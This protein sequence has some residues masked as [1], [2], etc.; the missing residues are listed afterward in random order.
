MMGRDRRGGRKKLKHKTVRHAG[1]CLFKQNPSRFPPR[2]FPFFLLAVFFWL[3]GTMIRGQDAEYRT[4]YRAE[5]QTEDR[6]EYRIEE[7]DRFIQTLRWEEQENVLY[8]EGEI[9]KQAGALWE[10]VLTRKTEASFLEVSLSPGLYRFRVRAYDFLERPGPAADWIQFEILPAKKP[11]LVRF[12]PTMFYLDEDPTWVINLFGG[13][14]TGGI[15]VFLK[16]TRGDIIQP[17][18]IRVDPS[19]SE[20]RLTFSYERLNTGSYTIHVINPGGLTEELQTFRI[21]FRK[22]VDINVSAGYR[23]LV[24]LYGYINELL[25]SGFFP[26]GAFGRLGFVPF[27]Q[28]WGYIGFELEPSW[29]YFLAEGKDF[30]VQAHIVGAAVCGVYQYWF[31][32]RAM[33]FNFRIGGGIYPVLDYHFTFDKGKTTPITILLP[34]ITAGVSFQWL[35]QKPF[36]VEAGLDF[37]HFFTVDDPSPGYLRPFAGLGWRF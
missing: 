8:Y 27:K 15:E 36:F 35:I 2:V 21:A 34:A 32:N 13:N 16:G 19:E 12:S 37:T 30:N 7:G 22:P 5:D 25:E 11:E 23:P 24:P 18:T 1:V 29:N 6:A 17:D 14:L 20:V 10:G 4:E 3:P 31:S 9:E 33:A 26:A 28:R